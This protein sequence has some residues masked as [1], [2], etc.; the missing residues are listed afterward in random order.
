MLA[1][2]RSFRAFVGKDAWKYLVWSIVM[3][4]LWFLIESSFLLVLQ[5]FLFSIGFL[6]KQQ[7]IMPSWYPPSFAASIVIMLSFGFL[8]SLLQMLKQHLATL[9]QQAYI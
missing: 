9:T 6:T 7:A 2:I 3:G 8:R 1:R 4:F 5:G